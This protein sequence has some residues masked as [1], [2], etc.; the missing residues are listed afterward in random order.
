MS[1]TKKRVAVLR[2]GP[3]NEYDISLKTGASV[4]KHLPE[5]YEGIDVLIDKQGVWHIDGVPFH[6]K[7]FHLRADVAFNAMHGEYGED[8]TVQRILE[9]WSIPY[10]GSKS[11]A[12]GIGMNKALSKEIF[13][14]FNI[15][16]PIHKVLK[17]DEVNNIEEEARNLFMTFTQPSVVKPVNAGSSIGVSMV[18]SI[19]DMVLALENAF[20][21][22]NTILIEE[23]IKGKEITCGVL[24]KFRNKE[25]YSLLPVEIVPRQDHTFFDYESKYNNETIA[26]ELCPANIRRADSEEVQRIA[27]EAHK[28][29]GARHYSRIDFILSPKRGA[30][31][32]EINTLPGLTDAS[33]LP[34]ELTA[35]GSSYGE[36]LEH[37]IE[38]AQEKK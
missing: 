18:R 30:Y 14:Q 4:L 7:D 9:M 20:S 22:S 5:K 2:G 13:K 38:L 37:L 27:V 19:K 25:H 34:K 6:P 16:T 10:T 21:I 11:L 31:V 35:I 3:S 26:L 32:L 1:I 29:I 15:K 12:S 23:F 8:G 36:L 17:K 24:E 28:A 33:L